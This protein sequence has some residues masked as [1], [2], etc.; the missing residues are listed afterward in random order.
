MNARRFSVSVVSVVALVT[1]AAGVTVL[2]Q[3][4]GAPP[5]PPPTFRTS[6]I[7]VEV[8]AFVTD[9][10]GHFVRGL[11]RDD[12]EVLEDKKPQEIA[13]FSLVD[14]PTPIRQPAVS[15]ARSPS[16]TDVATN[17][18]EGRVYLLVA[19]LL[20]LDPDGMLS[21]G[22]AVTNR[23]AFVRTRRALNQFA[24]ENVAPGDLVGLV[25]LGYPRH[26]FE[27]TANKARLLA[28]I[29]SLIGSPSGAAVGDADVA[30]S[31]K[32]DAA[33]VSVNELLS[34]LSDT[35]V[36]KYVTDLSQAYQALGEAA[37]YLIG[38]HGRRKI[39]VMFSGGTAVDFMDR[40]ISPIVDG[41]IRAA[42]RANIS[43]YTV[44]ARGLSA[45]RTVS[46][47]K[48]VVSRGNS[49]ASG[50]SIG[51]DALRVLSDQ[52][53]GRALLGY[54][55]FA[56]P[57][58]QI[59]E[60]SSAYYVFGYYGPPVKQDG[61]F[62]NITVRVKRPGLEVRARKGYYASS[63]KDSKVVK[64]IDDAWAKTDIPSLLSRSVPTGDLGLVLRATAAPITVSGKNV[65][66]AVSIEVGAGSLTFENQSG[67][68][69]TDVEVAHMAVDATGVTRAKGTEVAN[70]RLRPLTHDAT[71]VHG[72]RF[73][74]QVDLVPGR[75]QL[76][77]A[78]KQQPNGHAGAVFLDL[79][80]PDFARPPLQIGAIA[81]SSPRARE[82]PTAGIVPALKGLLPG[83][84]IAE[85]TFHATD[86]I[87]IFARV[88]ENV[89]T[90]AH[91]VEIATTIRTAG[92]A[93]E[94]LRTGQSH[95]AA[96]VAA[97]A[98]GY[99]AILPLT[100]LVPGAYVLRI[101]ATSSLGG[102]PVSRELPFWI[103]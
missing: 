65:T 9:K 35:E 33:D 67:V 18:I 14:L 28:N 91:T 26:G 42:M 40:R 48:A 43:I 90:P 38:V 53:G 86:T 78:V 22:A 81:L 88:S 39:V 27:F 58:R 60:D 57:F 45:M 61:A 66:V 6:A 80:V 75:Y 85:R 21:D 101:S 98:P 69:S 74:T 13:T 96:D 97:S 89:P 76:R 23:S 62:H 12:F 102:T 68:F 82:M 77:L 71:M 64:T 56:E 73:Q 4:A 100:H 37:Q 94:V 10:D 93:R 72:W 84:S 7:Y 99:L 47:T 49:P 5:Q 15:A 34:R 8:D 63:S 24:Q 50:A 51:W 41:V 11:T 2:A 52:T 70:L 16:Q 29:D 79:D 20:N 19:D 32:G 36:D 25:A 31:G 87:G 1:L 46:L 83:P 44:D 3:R 103:E 95:P 55:D 92:D 17:A 59:V 54:N 30:G